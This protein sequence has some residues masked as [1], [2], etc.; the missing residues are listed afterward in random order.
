MRTAAV[1]DVGRV[2]KNNEDSLLAVEEKIGSLPN[3]FIVADGMGGENAGDYASVYAVKYIEDCLSASDEK[4]PVSA[5][6]EAIEEANTK[7]YE[8]SLKKAELKGMGTTLVA[9]FISD[10]VL[11]TANIGDSRLYIINENIEQITRDH[12]YVEELA[13]LGKLERNSEEYR[14]CKNYI[15]RAVGTAAGIEPD[16]FEIG[17]KEGDIILLCSDGLSNMLE[18]KRIL[19]IV[20]EERD[21]NSAAKRLIDEA[22]ASGGRDNISVVLISYDEGEVRI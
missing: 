10:G 11:Y 22:N 19:K 5:L 4:E 20:K 7:L 17:I 6:R 1:T 21:L 12:S 9:A 14:S 16:F 15:T 2:R 8:Q 13:S 3:L 18:N